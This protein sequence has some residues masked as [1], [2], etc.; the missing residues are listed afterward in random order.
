MA[1]CLNRCFR[2][3][4]ANLFLGSRQQVV[5]FVPLM[6]LYLFHFWIWVFGFFQ[7]A[8]HSLAVPVDSKSFCVVRW[9]KMRRTRWAG[10]KFLVSCPMI[11]LG[12]YLSVEL[13]NKDHTHRH[14][15]W[16]VQIRPF[17]QHAIGSH[18]FHCTTFASQRSKERTGYLSFHRN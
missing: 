4:G 13:L 10:H 8:S 16:N 2:L 1:E 3:F 5:R 9:R 15:W 12:V 7:Q 11:S 14:F 6:G 18:I 17:M